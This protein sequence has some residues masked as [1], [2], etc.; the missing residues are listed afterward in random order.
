MKMKKKNF[1]QR[2]FGVAFFVALLSIANLLSVIPFPMTLSVYA[3][4]PPAIRTDN[5][6]INGRTITLNATVT[7]SG[8]SDF[9]PLQVGWWVR[10]N[11][12]GHYQRVYLPRV[13]PG[14]NRYRTG[15][16]HTETFTVPANWSGNITIRAFVSNDWHFRVNATNTVSVNIPATPTPG[17]TP[18]APTGVS[19]NRMS[20]SLQVGN[21]ETLRATVTP[22]NASNR[23]V[24]WR[25]SNNN[26]ARVNNGIVTA[27]STGTATITASTVNGR[28]ATAT[29]SVAHP[30]P[31]PPVTINPVSVS[32]STATITGNF[33]NG[34]D[35]IW[36]AIRTPTG[37][38]PTRNGNYNPMPAGTSWNF[39]YTI[40]NLSPG[41]HHIAIKTRSSEGVYSSFV[42]RDF[43]VPRPSSTSNP[44][45]GISFDCSDFTPGYNFWTQTDAR[46]RYERY[47]SH[48]NASL[49]G[50][51]GPDNPLGAA[52]GL[53]A[54]KNALYTIGIKMTVDDLHRAAVDSRARRA[55]DGTFVRANLLP[56]IAESAGFTFTGTGDIALAVKHISQDRGSAIIN[57]HNH[58]MTLVEYD[59]TTSE[60][61]VR[62]PAPR[63]RQNRP[64]LSA[65]GEA[66]G[67]W[68][69]SSVLQNAMRVEN[70]TLLSRVGGNPPR[71]RVTSTSTANI[72][73]APFEYT[74]P[75]VSS[76]LTA[77][78]V[79]LTGSVI[80]WSPVIGA[81]FYDIFVNNHFAVLTGENRLDLQSLNL[82]T[83]THR[84]EV[85]PTNR[86]RTSEADWSIPVTW[87]N[88]P[89]PASVPP[90]PPAA[91]HNLTDVTRRFAGQTVS[92]RSLE[93]GLY[94]S[95]ELNMTGVPLRARASAVDSWEK[96]EV[97]SVAGGYVAFRT[98]N[99]M[100]VSQQRN[101]ANVPV[102]AV[103]PAI[104]EWEHF[105][106]FQGDGHYYIQASDGHF[107]SA[108][109]NNNMTPLQANIEVACRWERFQIAVIHL[110]TGF[111]SEAIPIQPQLEASPATLPSPHAV[112]SVAPYIVYSLADDVNFQSIAM[113]RSGLGSTVV[114]NTPHIIDSGRPTFTIVE[115][116]NN[117]NALQIS[118]RNEYWYA[119][120]FMRT[121]WTM[122][123]ATNTYRI[124]IRGTAT[125]GSEVVLGGRTAPW[126][127]LHSVN[128]NANG[129]FTIETTLSDAIFIAQTEGGAS[130]FSSGFRV[131]V[132]NHYSYTIHEVQI[133]RQ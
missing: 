72:R 21:S 98:A 62:S 120:D 9:F 38:I 91:P 2:I 124:I 131:Q 20:L 70:I 82:E 89:N 118:N 39:S 64:Y 133:I 78:I 119:V 42:Q 8:G 106:I 6:R 58:F 12:S 74:L 37:R 34:V 27:V 87:H 105:R 85:V 57:V 121:T 14:N 127:R 88:Q 94:I 59:T 104:L 55:N 76:R 66:D 95:T 83:G 5:A 54:T 13:Q 56:H 68:V 35:T 110:T 75:V 79:T 113:G 1:A 53:F 101:V 33:L 43:Y 107:V 126:N 86:Q 45:N 63:I 60:F 52:C 96:Y 16:S 47:G 44:V 130:Q 26:V 32:G 4:A 80:S 108:R 69:H 30:T 24:T 17:A 102:S 132:Q 115:S 99:G 3:A 128:A 90:T 29:V 112:A 15:T 109:V 111:V 71:H 103:A 50:S 97:V 67:R 41:P 18:T 84:I 77:P 93:N 61:L 73:F 19:L 23:S 46:W 65:P 10:H 7:A 129:S 123:S 31:P 100:Y 48:A 22:S 49:F 25:S 11:D 36:Y 114:W 92:I 28:T 125:P 81:D 122:N 40:R 116:P 51:G 117:G